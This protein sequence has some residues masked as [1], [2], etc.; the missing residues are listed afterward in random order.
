MNAKRRQW[1][2]ELRE[3]QEAI[4]R[5]W[6]GMNTEF[7]YSEKQKQTALKAIDE[8]GVRAVARMLS[9]PRRTLQ[10]WCRREGKQVKRCPDWVYTWAEK[11]R[12]R[13]KNWLWPA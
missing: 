5:A 2:D 11:R 8:H 3:T 13:R 10:R 12:E 7:R 4:R 9:V 1:I 6:R